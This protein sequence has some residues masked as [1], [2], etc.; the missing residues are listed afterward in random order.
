MGRTTTGGYSGPAG[1]WVVALAACGLTAG[2]LTG[3]VSFGPNPQPSVNLA[4]LPGTWV[5]G[6]GASIT[7]TGGDEFTAANFNY[8]R[9]MAWCCCP[10]AK[11][12]SPPGRAHMPDGSN[13]FP[14]SMRNAGLA[15]LNTPDR[16]PEPMRH[17]GPGDA[18]RVHRDP[19]GGSHWPCAWSGCA[20]TGYCHRLCPPP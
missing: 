9:V 2:L 4:K 6:D 15:L 12:S 7:F 16:S 10:M 19:A 11:D 5:S 20:R 18:L 3:C 14:T 1:R 8:G 17:P 13:R